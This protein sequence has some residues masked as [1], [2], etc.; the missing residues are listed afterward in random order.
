MADKDV[1]DSL[2]S[3]SVPKMNMSNVAQPALTA[4]GL[5]KTCDDIL[6]MYTGGKYVIQP[7]YFPHMTPCC[8]R[9]YDTTGE[10]ASN[11]GECP[12]DC[13]K[14]VPAGHEKWCLIC[15]D[16]GEYLDRAYAKTDDD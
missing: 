11:T 14:P 12:Y 2:L 4:E 15:K 16:L 5:K 3:N 1:W 9:R 8:E 6:K 7:D 13:G 10:C